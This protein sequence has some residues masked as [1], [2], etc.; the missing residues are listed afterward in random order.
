MS[1][2]IRCSVCGQM[3]NKEEINKITGRTYICNSCL[4]ND[5]C[6]YFKCAKCG[7]I[8][9][10]I[11]RT[12]ID[13]PYG[14]EE[15]IP[16]P[17]FVNVNNGLVCMRCYNYYYTVC[18]VC[19]KIILKKDVIEA[20]DGSF[21][22]EECINENFKVCPRCGYTRRKDCFVHIE[23]TD[24]EVCDRCAPSFFHYC[25]E[26]N[27]YYSTNISMTRTDS[28]DKICPTCLENNNYTTCSNC[29]MI[30]LRQIPYRDEDT[31]QPLCGSCYNRL[32]SYQIRSY[33][34]SSE[35][36]EKRKSENDERD[37]KLY[38][39]LELEV[40]GRT[41]VAGRFYRKVKNDVILMS[42]SS[43]RDG[44]FEI[45][46]MPMTQKYFIETFRQKLAEGLKVLIENDFKGHNYGGLH[47]HVSDEALDKDQ[48]AQ[49]SEILY[50]N[51]NDKETWLQIT[52]RKADN[53]ARWSKMDNRVNFY[54][55]LE[56]GVDKPFV[57]RD[58][59]T[60]LNHST[61]THTYEF[62]IFNSSL[63]IERILKNIQ[64]V[65]ALLDYSKYHA[66]NERPVCNTTEFL[67]FVMS[68][69]IFYPELAEFIKEK[70]IL[71]QHLNKEFNEIPDVSDEERETACA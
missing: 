33:H 31:E 37:E 59:Y 17:N 6:E 10:K 3:H 39:G 58:R 50:G 30:I 25:S 29:G 1:R 42:D 69:Q 44:G 19:N 7:K 9:N 68:R 60:A 56:A 67:K 4:E 18:E 65:F 64:C 63:R 57:G 52:Q 55:I 15:T 13:M 38:F 8:H 23:D 26:C 54:D 16:N 2:R 32:Y 66:K 46:T 34:D 47:I 12:A 43:I 27:K 61:R 35:P 28:G 45:V 71:E 48:V 36:F 21:C 70:N 41:D 5:D 53:M 11:I 20:I 62:R 22:C 40:S 14:E 24:Q 49:L 51:K